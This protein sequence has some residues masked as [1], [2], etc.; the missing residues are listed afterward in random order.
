MLFLLEDFSNIFVKSIPKYLMHV[1][2]KVVAA[3]SSKLPTIGKLSGIKSI[4]PSPKFK[5]YI[6][7]IIP[8]QKTINPFILVTP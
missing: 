3:A 4:T 8:K 5:R 7:E 1:S 2:N 6:K